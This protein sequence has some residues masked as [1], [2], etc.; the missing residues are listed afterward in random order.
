MATALIEQGETAAG[1]RS[2]GRTLALDATI[3][4]VLFASAAIVIGL[5]WDIAWHRA[6]GR[7]TFWSPPHVL[8]QVAASVAGLLCGW[9]VLYTSFW[10]TDA[11]RAACVRWWRMFYGPLGGWVCIWGTI[12]M[13]TSAPFDDWW[14]SAYGLDVEILTPPHVFLLSG[15]VSVQLGAM[16]MM[17]A[18][19]NRAGAASGN[20]RALLFCTSMGLIVLMFA[21]M[22]FEYAGVPNFHRSPLFY[23]IT[24]GLFPLLLLAVS[25]AGRLRYAATVAA[26]TYMVV[27]LGL[28]WVLALVPATPMLAPIYNQVTTLVPPGFP[29][30]LIAPALVI[31]VL[32]QRLASRNVW[33]LAAAS[34][35][36]FVVVLVTVQWPFSGFL[37]SLE[38]PNYLTG[39]GYWDYTERLGPWTT[40]FFDV[41]GYQW[42]PAARTMV[43]SLDVA[44]MARAL[45]VATG[46]AIVASRLGIAWGDWMRRVQR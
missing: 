45:L 20:R 23:Q 35:V 9:R 7:D 26:A 18:E 2:L 4:A 5:H 34:G 24:G 37:L 17:L 28:D 44:A 39:T 3:P 16:L 19:Q 32:A 36:A 13:I 21:T 43:G 22:V 33:L 12:A 31:D 42:D 8:E 15:M 10:G 38:Q 6:I 46:I 1:R 27:M 40:A 29:I 41:P 11:D 25:R 14:H 30:L